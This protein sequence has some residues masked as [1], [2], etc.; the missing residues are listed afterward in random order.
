VSL[1]QRIKGLD[2]LEANVELVLR[3]TLLLLIFHGGSSALSVV[4]RV[5]AAA[6]LFAPPLLKKPAAWWGLFIALAFMH[7]QVWFRI[8]NHQYLLLYWTGACALAC[9]LED[10]SAELLRIQGRLLVGLSFGFAVFWKLWGGQWL[11]GS[12]FHFTFLADGRF[13]YMLD[14]FTNMNLQDRI[15]NG[16]CFRVLSDFPDSNLR[17]ELKSS[18]MLAHAALYFG[19]MA[20]ALEALVALTFMAPRLPIVG[21]HRDL[22]LLLFI[23]VTYVLTPV[24]GFG[25][26]L[27]VMGFA[28]LEDGFRGRGILYVLIIPLVKIAPIFPQLPRIWQD[29]WQY[30]LVIW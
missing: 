8:D 4:P 25:F 23:M 5:L 10:K 11:D 20:L 14:L 7:L 6:M 30:H 29:F 22:F 27:C 19:L 2:W 28:Q 1:W 24:P 3:L 12:F 15:D 13:S 18:T 21:K 16:D 9:T 17:F 26:L